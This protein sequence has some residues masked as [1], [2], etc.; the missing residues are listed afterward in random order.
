MNYSCGVF[1]PYGIDLASALD[2]KIDLLLSNS[3]LGKEDHILDIRC[4]WGRLLIKAVEDY[5]CMATGVTL[6]EKQYDYCV[7]LVHD[8]GLDT[9]VKILL[10]DYRT[11]RGQFDHIYS[12]EMLEAVGHAGLKEFF[13]QSNSLLKRFGTLGVQV[14]TIPDERYESYRKN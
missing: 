1:E 10:Q 12:V 2:K 9:R 6:S 3:N 5:G 11:V 14:I 13:F 8:L 4:G 7:K